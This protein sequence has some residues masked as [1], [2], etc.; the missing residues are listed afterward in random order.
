MTDEKRDPWIKWFPAD[1]RQEPSLRMC[2]RAARS[3]WFDMLCLMHEATPY[4]YLVI[5]GRPITPEQLAHIFGDKP[6]DV[7]KWLEEM[8]SAHVFSRDEQ[9]RIYSRRMINDKAKRAKNISNGGKGGNPDIPRGTVPKA[10]RARPYRRADSP[11]KTKRIFDRTEG[12]CHWCGVELLFEPDGGPNGFHVDHVIA[13]CDGGTNEESN[14]VAA[15]ASCNHERARLDSSGRARQVGVGRVSDSNPT[16]QS[17]TNPRP[18]FR[19]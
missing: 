16:H 14:L 3:L 17:D 19:Q 5:T 15:C 12:H 11:E 8:E 4:G 6:R 18:P 2:S 1:W 13:I 10:Q 7:V 9:G